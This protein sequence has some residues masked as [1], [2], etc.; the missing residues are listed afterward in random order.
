MK[1]TFFRLYAIVIYAITIVLF[2]NNFYN[3]VI[4][5]RD[6]DFGIINDNIENKK[7][8][9]LDLF[10]YK[11]LYYFINK[12]DCN[13]TFNIH[14][15][16]SLDTNSILIDS[17]IYSTILIIIILL[18]LFAIDMFFSIYVKKYSTKIVPNDNIISVG[19][20]KD[21]V[22]S[23]YS[24]FNEN[25]IFIIM[26]LVCIIPLIII[27]LYLKINYSNQELIIN[28]KSHYM[29]NKDNNFL[30]NII[31]REWELI[32]DKAKKDDF[33]V[34]LSNSTI[35]NIDINLI[36]IKKYDNLFI[37]IY[38][39]CIFLKKQNNHKTN[40]FTK[41]YNILNTY[42]KKVKKCDISYSTYD[43]NNKINDENEIII[44]SSLLQS[45]YLIEYGE[46]GRYDIKDELKDNTCD[47]SIIKEWLM[48]LETELGVKTPDNKKYLTNI[49]KQATGIIKSSIYLIF[50]LTLIIVIFSL[51]MLLTYC[52]KIKQ[53][54]TIIKYSNHFGVKK[55]D[56]LLTVFFNI[57]DRLCNALKKLY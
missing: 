27:T 23:I 47:Y 21:K 15:E 50:T 44:L 20:Y 8:T 37:K 41:M 35:Y 31:K 13:R 5:S 11:T 12:N 46:K 36:N 33:K 7:Y 38:Y 17:F 57:I 42:D 54:E 48:Q 16:L 29:I 40:V 25:K 56:D 10:N 34:L 52:R 55:I 32:N 19:G 2:I 28:I 39:L 45:K 51:L 9:V 26:T 24:I 53:P 49:M 1:K 14:K 30:H 43:S 6:T 22:F 18:L 3:L 4:L